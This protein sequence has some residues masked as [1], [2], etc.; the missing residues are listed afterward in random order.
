[1]MNKALLYIICF[2]FLIPVWGY[3]QINKRKGTTSDIYENEALNSFELEGKVVESETYLPIG[4]V[5]VE[6]TGKGY[7][8]TNSE[9]VFRLELLNIDKYE[10]LV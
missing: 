9:G 8:T 4:R 2:S 6:I 1:M 7:T 10:S 3:G 5:N